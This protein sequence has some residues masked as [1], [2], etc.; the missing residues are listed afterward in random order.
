MYLCVCV[1]VCVGVWVCVCVWVSVWV[2]G[3]V[4]VCVCGCVGVWVC[5]WVCGCVGGCVGVKGGSVQLQSICSCL[6][7]KQSQQDA[8]TFVVPLTE[9]LE[10]SEQR[11][12]K[13]GLWQHL[14]T[15]WGRKE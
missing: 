12:G 7:S 6:L 13:S 3:W 8:V 4:C 2:C 14:A 11:D 15:C 1:W 5:G 9:Q 10:E